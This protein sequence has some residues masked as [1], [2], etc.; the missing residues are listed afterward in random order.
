[1]SHL[2]HACYRAFEVTTLI[3]IIIIIIIIITLSRLRFS[4]LLRSLCWKLFTDFPGYTE[5]N[6]KH[7]LYN[8][9]EERRSCTQ[10][11]GILKSDITSDVSSH[12]MLSRLFW[13]FSLFC[14]SIFLTH[15]RTF[16]LNVIAQE[17]IK[18]HRYKRLLL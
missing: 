17:H 7:S 2:F 4:G 3:I 14:L 8:N 18:Q 9:S 5:N 12:V 1:V 16:S 11:S 6:Y 15:S 10:R 13:F